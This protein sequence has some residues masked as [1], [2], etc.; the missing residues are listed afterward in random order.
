MK[1]K[2]RNKPTAK[3]QTM[4]EFAL[5]MP[6]LLL[7]LMGVIEFGWLIVNYTQLYNGLREGLRY[8][9]VAGWPSAPNYPQYKDCAGIQQRI[10][11]MAPT[12][13][14]EINQVSFQ[15]GLTPVSISYDAGDGSTQVG[16]CNPTTQAF[17]TFTQGGRD[18]QTGD[19]I[20][21]Q[22]SATVHFL[23]P[24]ISTFEPNGLTF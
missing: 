18:I 11:A 19:R 13:S 15:G 14:W 3:G 10:E 5:V 20:V 22:I 4:V 2:R 23:T 24:I 16:F 6:M 21:I 8:G 12:A 9:T 1:T 7:L 17:Q